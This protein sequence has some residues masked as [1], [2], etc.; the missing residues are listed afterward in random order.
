MTNQSP[1]ST[2]DSKLSSVQQQRHDSIVGVYGDA[3]VQ[4][5]KT[6]IGRGRNSWPS[7]LDKMEHYRKAKSIDK[8]Y[9]DALYEAF[10]LE[11]L[12]LPGSVVGN[13]CEV[14]REMDLPSYTE[15]IKI[16]CERDFFLIFVVEDVYEMA[17]VDGESKKVFKGYKPILRIKPE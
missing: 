2:N 11:T 1:E 8:E 3:S 5:V 4:I 9:Y 14:R 10:E 17:I 12:Y 13:V 6:V 7:F 16:Q 15:R